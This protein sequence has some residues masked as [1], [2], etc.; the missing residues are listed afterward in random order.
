MVATH[1]IDFMTHRGVTTCS[2]KILAPEPHDGGRRQKRP[3]IRLWAE[4][5][6]KGAGRRLHF[7]TLLSP[8]RSHFLP[9]RPRRAQLGGLR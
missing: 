3:L 4:G 5:G 2:M 8:S 1:Y 9:Q 7:L 6:E